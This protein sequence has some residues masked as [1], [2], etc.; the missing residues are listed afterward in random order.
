LREFSKKTF[1]GKKIKKP[2][3]G[4]NFKNYLREYSWLYK[5]GIFRRKTRN[6]HRLG[7]EGYFTYC[8]NSVGPFLNNIT[9]HGH[10][11]QNWRRP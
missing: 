5:K 3:G 9:S 2:L 10:I 11:K 4:N 8:K 6:D 7:T 1:G